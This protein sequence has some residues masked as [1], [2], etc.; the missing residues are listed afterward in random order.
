MA[1]AAG[2]VT[3]GVASFVACN[4]N[5]PGD[6]SIAR[7]ESLDPVQSQGSRQQVVTGDLDTIDLEARTF[8][9]NAPDGE[10][11]FSFTTVT[12]V[13][14]AAGPQGLSNQTGARVTVYYESPSGQEPAGSIGETMWATRIVLIEGESDDQ[15]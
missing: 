7:P 4:R 13:T 11:H 10:Y 2:I 5:E 3:L 14:G 12:D 8:T 9:V 1:L 6:A 15:R